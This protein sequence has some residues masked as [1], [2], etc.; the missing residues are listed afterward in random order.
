[1]NPL[2]PEL[3]QAVL[4]VT[5]VVVVAMLLTLVAQRTLRRRSL[6]RTAALDGL[7]RRLVLEATIAED[8][9]LEPLLDRV[10]GLSAAERAHVGRTVF[11][12][13]RDV[14]GEAADR[15]RSVA[16]ASGLVPSVLDATGHRSAVARADAAEALGLLAP[17][18]ALELLLG[19]AGDRDTEV[20]TVAIRA[21]GAFDDTAA[22]DRVIAALASD[23]G[24]PAS[25][26]ATALLQQGTAAVARVRW[27]LDDADPGV[28]RGAARVAGL[29]QV[30]AAGEALTRLVS[31]E[32]DFVRLAAMRSLELLPVRAS[33][34]AL[35]D[36]ALSGGTIGEA[37][38][39]AIVRMPPSWQ[40]DALAQ[41]SA[42][43]EPGVRRAAGLPRV[44]AVA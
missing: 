41:I 24:V 20:R 21:L 43:A 15:L 42:R 9:E 2:P 36:A 29:L 3:L 40:A 6:R 22:I 38:A 31:D 18:G 19:L 4:L 12:M 11:L 1:M 5:S 27:A 39:S 23:S 8:D 7:H 30:P 28:R 10:R 32:H 25:V 35:L 37:A 44:E 16:L 17:D 14:T 34:P 33:L 26:A 13:L